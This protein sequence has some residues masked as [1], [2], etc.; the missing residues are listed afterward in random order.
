MVAVFSNN[1]RGFKDIALALPLLGIA[2]KKAQKN[3][4]NQKLE[5][6]AALFP[7]PTDCDSMRSTIAQIKATR[8]QKI[9]D[10]AGS[11]AKSTKNDLQDEIVILTNMDKDYS[12][13]LTKLCA[14]AVVSSNNTAPV[15]VPDTQ[16]KNVPANNSDMQTVASPANSLVQGTA[17]TDTGTNVPAATKKSYWPWIIGGVLVLGVGYYFIR[18]KN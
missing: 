6:Y 18:K 12:A 11:K 16:T 14:Q 8:E 17:T 7:E 5:E 4:Y 10:K 15:N 1:D 2:N 3:H 13:K 9:K